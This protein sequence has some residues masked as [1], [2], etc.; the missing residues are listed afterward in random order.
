[1]VTGVGGVAGCDQ[2]PPPLLCSLSSVD[3]K[4]SGRSP[5]FAGAGPHN[6]EITGEGGGESEERG[7]G[8][9]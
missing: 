2:Q 8:L 7:T 6:P 5:P 4:E 1:M 3:Q 9:R